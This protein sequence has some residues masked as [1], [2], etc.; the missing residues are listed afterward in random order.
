[1]L[2]T[3]RQ[4]GLTRLIARATTLRAQRAAFSVAAL[5]LDAAVSCPSFMCVQLSVLTQNQGWRAQDTAV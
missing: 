4:P 2:T 5:R 1:M 3:V